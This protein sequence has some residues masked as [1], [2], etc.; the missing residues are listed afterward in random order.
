MGRTNIEI[1]KE[2]HV[3]ASTVGDWRKLPEFAA[4]VKEIHDELSEARIAR[5]KSLGL[6]A[7]ETLAGLMRGS[8]DDAVRRNSAKD[9]LALLGAFPSPK[10]ELHH[11]GKVETGPELDL[12][13]LT[14]AELAAYRAAL[15]KARGD[16][17]DGTR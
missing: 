6:E 1:G 10:Q 4:R 12:K 3:R 17:D 9:V 7:V 5:A 13:R 15:R 8:G 16:D 11:T 14:D 2:L